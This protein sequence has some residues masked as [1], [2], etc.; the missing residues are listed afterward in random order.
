MAQ[1]KEQQ[2]KMRREGRQ[3]LVAV[4]HQQGCAPHMHWEQNAGSVL[5]TGMLLSLIFK[6]SKLL[7][8]KALTTDEG[9]PTNFTA[10]S[11]QLPQRITTLVKFGI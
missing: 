2:C 11:K 1:S 7:A 8:L 9:S 5:G 10:L 6:K 3:G 4:G